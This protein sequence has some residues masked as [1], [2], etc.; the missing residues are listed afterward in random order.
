M[1]FNEILTEAVNPKIVSLL[2][3]LGFPNQKTKGNKILVYIDIPPKAHQG[4]IRANVL[5]QILLNFKKKKPSLKPYHNMDASVLSQSSVGT[6]SFENDPTYIVIKPAGEGGGGKKAAGVE[7]EENLVKMMQEQIDAFKSINVIFE[8]ER[9]KKLALQDVTKIEH[10][11][12]SSGR[13]T[14]GKEIKKADVKLIS[15]KKNLPI[16]IKQVNAG[17]WESSDTL[18]GKRG[19]EIIKKLIKDGE[20]SLIETT[21]GN[22]NLP[23]S[24][25]VEPTEE[26]AM[27]TL[28]GADINPEGG[29]VVQDFQP[30][31][32]T[33]QGNYI[34][35]MCS[36][37]IVTKEDIPES[38]LMV[39]KI[40]NA[41]GRNPLG[42]RGLRPE[43]A[44]MKTAFGAAGSRE[45]LLVDQDGNVKRRPANSPKAPP[46]P[47]VKTPA[48]IVKKLNSPQAKPKTPPK[49]PVGKPMGTPNST[50]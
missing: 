31:H 48:P 6:I 30:H 38:H 37:I 36:A 46:K 44:T 41:S 9:G 10:S 28:F 5:Q 25:I 47:I 40:R 29:I 13:R 24:V 3:D 21:P 20:L 18:F 22:F 34:K 17:F 16:S 39:W 2:G 1:R 4:K 19:G 26:E 50:T 12:K 45:V 49:I 32:F 27:K 43:A 7:N 42:I 11:G 14:G 35:I 33:Q 15:A 8:D 23:F